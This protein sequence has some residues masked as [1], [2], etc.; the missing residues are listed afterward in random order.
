M[1]ELTE[2]TRRPPA[3]DVRAGKATL[4]APLSPWVLGAGL[5][6]L[7]GDV[8]EG[9]QVLPYVREDMQRRIQEFLRLREAE[10]L[11]K[12]LEGA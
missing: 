9:P 2:P 3:A 10:R 1:R 4:D 12:L 7:A 5:N 6:S 11:R 8:E